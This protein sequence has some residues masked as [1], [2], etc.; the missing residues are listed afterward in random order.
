M[1]FSGAS[2][3]TA[4]Q[5]FGKSS[6]LVCERERRTMRLRIRFH[7]KPCSSIPVDHNAQAPTRYARALPAALVCQ[8]QKFPLCTSGTFVDMKTGKLINREGVLLIRWE[9]H[10][11]T[12]YRTPS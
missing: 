10:L 1:V 2:F 5:V 7:N 12:R 6:A 11:R 3:F 9:C 8:S 4:F